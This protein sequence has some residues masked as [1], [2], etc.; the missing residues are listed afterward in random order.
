MAVRKDTKARAIPMDVKRAVAERDS[1]DG[2]PCCVYCGTPA[3]PETPTAFSCA[4]YISRGQ[5]GLGIEENIV[6]LCPRCHH[7]YDQTTDRN[8]IR[9]YL[10]EYLMSKY[11]GWNEEKLAYKK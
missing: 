5:D 3:P 11:N 2:H 7:R 10:R 6:T 4:H 1:F 8:I 9:E